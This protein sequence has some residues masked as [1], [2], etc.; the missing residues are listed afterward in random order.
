MGAD[1]LDLKTISL[2]VPKAR[3][4]D[5]DARNEVCR[6]VQDYLQAMAEKKLDHSLRR[7]VNAADMVQQTMT[8]MINGFDGFRGA[9]SAEFYGWLNRILENEINA[10]RRNLQRGKRDIRREQELA[11]KSGVVRGPVPAD[12]NLTPGSEAIKEEKLRQFHQVLDRLPV[13]Y[14]QVI[15]LRS[16]QEMSFKEVAMA[17]DKSYDSVSKLWYRAIVRFQEE[18]EKLDDTMI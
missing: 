18:L 4:G 16:L 13:D 10:T 11:E 2:L 12:P 5:E 3:D 6:R 7:R 9:S 17:M 15:R 8:R 14:C 1:Q